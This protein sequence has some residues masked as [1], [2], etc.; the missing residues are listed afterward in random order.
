MT[1]GQEKH[2]FPERNVESDTGER[3]ENYDL[4]S[5][6]YHSLQFA[7]ACAQYVRDAER[8]GEQQLAQFFEEARGS[9]VEL[10]QQAKQLLAARLDP[11]EEDEE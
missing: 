6:L 2:P 10:A 7:E 1:T 3:D 4:I 5:V 9:H 8:K 11:T